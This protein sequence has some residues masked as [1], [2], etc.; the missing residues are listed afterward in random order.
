M[1]SEYE[2]VRAANI[3]RN[4]GHYHAYLS[5]YVSSLCSLLLTSYVTYIE[6]MTSLGLDSVKADMKEFPLKTA[7]QKGN[8]RKSGIKRQA[9]EPVRRSSR[10]T[11]LKELAN[12]ESLR[13][14]GKVKEADAKQKEFDEIKRKKMEGDYVYHMTAEDAARNIEE[15]L[16][17]EPISVYPAANAP[18]TLTED[19]GKTWGSGFFDSIKQVVNVKATSK[20]KASQRASSSDDEYIKN[21][22]ALS[23]NPNDCAKVVENRIVSVLLHPAVDKVLL[24]AGDKSGN[25]G[26]WDVNYGKSSSV[27][28][29]GSYEGSPEGVYKYKPHI[30]N[31]T[32]LHT[33]ESSQSKVYSSSYDGTVRLV[34]DET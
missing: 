26:I 5:Y 34:E 21:L 15:R 10:S 28:A 13:S 22:K 25:L 3:K 14:E 4:E 30:A 29:G 6:F 7:T 12:I 18:D 17:R 24:F 8:N 33:W 19:E 23:L 2:R 32:S 27:K 20:S 31:I 16:P 9:V 11:E 1:S